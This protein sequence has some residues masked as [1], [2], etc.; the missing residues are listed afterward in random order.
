MLQVSPLATV[1]A[2][3]DA[4]AAFDFRWLLNPS[5]APFTRW[6]YKPLVISDDQRSSAPCCHHHRSVSGITWKL[7]QDDCHNCRWFPII[8]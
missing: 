7:F 8:A 1:A 3:S 5:L 6:S 4:I 2:K